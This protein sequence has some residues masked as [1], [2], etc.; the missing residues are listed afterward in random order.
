MGKLKNI[1]SW[2]FSAGEYFDQCRRRHYWKKY[3]SWGGWNAT[4]SPEIKKAYLLKNMNNRWGLMGQAAELAIMWMLKQY[5]D[6]NT[7]STDQVWDQIARPFSNLFF[8]LNI[9]FR[10]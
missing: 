3:G 8:I 7:V 5:Q 6:G 2:S 4:A 9:Q 1:F 10:K